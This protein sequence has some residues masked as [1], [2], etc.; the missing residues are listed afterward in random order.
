LDSTRDVCFR[1]LNSSLNILV[2][3]FTE[4]SS[5]SATCSWDSSCVHL[6]HCV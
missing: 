5:L 6:Q 4:L 2:I 1:D 3:N